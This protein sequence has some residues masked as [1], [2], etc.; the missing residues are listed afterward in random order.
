VEKLQYLLP[1]LVVLLFSLSFHEAAH[2]WAAN[3]LGDPTAKMR[4]R[5]TLNPLKHIDPLGTVLLPILLYF[6][7]GMIFGY[8][9]PVPV[10]ERNLRDHRWG[11]LLVAGAGPFSNLALA[12][13]FALALGLVTRIP[14]PSLQAPLQFMA[15][16][17]V[18]LNIILAIFNSFPLPPLDGSRVV[19]GFFPQLAGPFLALERY[20]FVLILLLAYTG[21]FKY[22]V[23]LPAQ[24][25]Y[26]VLVNW[27][28]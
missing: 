11:G 4:G 27:V 13:I 6:A 19:V 25:I 15:A 1:M 28:V 18:Q 2:A 12:V 17:G 3:R 5:L 24:I 14:V 7:G 9:K 26:R 10:D 8:A 23:F 21:I 16:A 22:L 20:G